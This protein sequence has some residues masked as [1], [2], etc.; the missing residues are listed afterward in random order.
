MVFLKIRSATK[1]QVYTLLI[2]ICISHVVYGQVRYSIP[3]EMAKGSI[4]GNIAED[5][6]LDI[7]RL[8]SGRARVIAGDSS[9][10]VE[11][12]TDKGI[13]V[14]NERMDRELLCRQISPCSFDFEVILENPIQLYR[15]TI[16]I[17]DVNDHAPTFPKDEIHLEISESALPGARFLLD[18]AFDP[19]VGVNTIQS[20]TLKPTDHFILK[21]H[22]RPDG[23]K[24]VEMMLQTP[25]DREK[26]GSLALILTAFDGGDPQRSGTLKINIIVLDANDNSPVFTQALYK[27]TVLENALS[28]SV[29][30]KV[31]ATDLDKGINGEVTYALTHTTANAEGLFQL[32]PNTG[33]I[34]VVGDIDFEKKKNYE[35]NVQ[36]KDHWGLIDSCKVI[37][38][39]VDL[40]DNVPTISLTS[41][42]S[43]ISEDSLPG[44]TVAVINIKDLDSGENGQVK[45]SI[46][47]NLPFIIKSSI[48]NYYTLLTEDKLDREMVSEYNITL[49]ATDEGSP[50]LSSNK[51]ILLKIS[52]VNDNP[53]VFEQKSYSANVIENNSPGLSIASV[54]ALDSDCCHNAR[55]S[56]LLD[57]AQVNGAAA[58]SYISVNSESGVIYAVRSFDYEHI[59]AIKINIIAQ[60]GGSPPL[61]SN[62]TVNIHIQDQNDNSP[63]ILYPVQSG[64]SL[65][66]E[67]VARSA[68]VGYL[69]T[70]VVAVDADSG[71][72][73]WLSYKL[74]KATDRALFEVGSQNGEI[75]TSRQVSDKDAVKQRLVVVVEDNGQPSRSA[76]VNVNVA[77][78]DSFPEVLSEFSD[79]THD[80]DYNDSLTFYLVLSLAVVSFLFIVSVIVLVSVKVYRWR[81]SRLFYKSN[82][83]LPVIP[84]AYYP[85]RYA[86]VGA[87][88]TLQH[89]YNYEVCMTTD[90]GKSEYRYIRPVSQNLVNVDPSGTETLRHVQK[91]TVNGEAIEQQ[92]VQF[93]EAF[94]R[95]GKKE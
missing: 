38:E 88:G 71:Q 72:N 51:T 66:A 28:G 73:A 83:N 7:K 10:Y 89:V 26:L 35:I 21:L 17:V 5:L 49:T 93:K 11:L 19:D 2:Y 85:P 44:T 24:Y 58:S 92:T 32:D 82:G 65:V 87:T 43:P 84:S 62:V 9:R 54:K 29:V 91:E 34:S 4:V 39:V 77:V 55:V 18:S 42:S 20:Y 14:V 6:G 94:I 16:E 57:D 37:I 23:S 13:L 48:T 67:M 90:S 78:A 64:V 75:R 52:D 46:S 33:E 41:F 70:K 79:F 27:A 74:L 80:K 81:Q 47:K 61:S 59:K 69:V 60:D 30:T 95:L 31:S 25:L 1:W 15:V 53:P 50:P 76:T 40:N 63:Q 86:D 12:N 3:E 8:K 68:D 45:C 22:A 56:Y 36:A